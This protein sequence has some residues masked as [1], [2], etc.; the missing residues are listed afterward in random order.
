MQHVVLQQD[1]DQP[2]TYAITLKVY[3]DINN[4]SVAAAIYNWYREGRRPDDDGL[5]LGVIA[6]LLHSQAAR[7][8]I[9]ERRY[10]GHE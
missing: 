1:C 5:D 10:F 2:L 4:L 3:E 7:D 9:L 6:D 8:S